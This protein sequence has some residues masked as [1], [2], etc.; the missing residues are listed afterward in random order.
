MSFH[1]CLMPINS[2]FLLKPLGY[3]RHIF[4]AGHTSRAPEFSY[5]SS[6]E[7]HRTTTQEEPRVVLKNLSSSSLS[8]YRHHVRKPHGFEHCFRGMKQPN[9]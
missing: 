2:F 8:L 4:A 1:N 3:M 5:D 6:G 9:G 7:G